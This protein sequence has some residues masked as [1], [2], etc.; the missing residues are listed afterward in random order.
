MEILKSRTAA[1][2]AAIVLFLAVGYIYCSPVLSGKTL[3]RF[4]NQMWRGA[5]HESEVYR[6]TTGDQ[7][8][9]TRSMFC[10]MPNYQ[11]GGAEYK[12]GKFIQPLLRF[13]DGFDRYGWT[14]FLYF[15]G[16]YVMFIAFGV[17]PWLSIVAA[18]ATGLSS[19]FIVLIPAGHTTKALTIATTAFVLGGFKFIYDKKY[20]PG[21]ILT[22]LFVSAGFNRHPQMFYYFCMMMGVLGLAELW[23]HVKEKRMKDFL[24]SSVIFV[25]SL[26]IGFGTRMSNVFANAE[27][28]SQTTRGGV[29]ELAQNT[30]E[31]PQKGLKHDSALTFSYGVDETLSLLIPGIKGGSTAMHTAKT[32]KLY[33]NLRNIGVDPQQSSMVAER[34]PL[35]WGDQPFT[36]GNVYVGA[37]VCFLFLLGLLVLE[38]PYKW[39]LLASTIFSILLAW[40]SNFYWFS[41]L[42]LDYFP[43]YNKFRAV[44][45][46]LVVAEV[47][48]P[49]LG[50]MTVK[51]II[52]GKLDREKLEN[53]ILLSA[54]ITAGL[55]LILA[56]FSGV[57]FD[58][59]GPRDSEIGTFSSQRIY[60]AFID[61]RHHLAVADCIRSAVII[62]AAAAALWFLTKTEKKKVALVAVLGAIM[63]IDLWGVDTRYFHK[64]AFMDPQKVEV[65]FEQT[66][67]EK[68]ILTDSTDFRVYNATTNTF[69]DART[70]YYL[71]SIGGYSSAK[72]RRYQDLIDRYL[73][74]ANLNVLAMLNTK[75][76]IT[77]GE[78][79][80]HGQIMTMKPYGNAWFVKALLVADSAKEE[81]DAVGFYDLSKAAVVGKDFSAFAKN[82]RPGVAYDAKIDL[83]KVSPKTLEYECNSSRAGTVVFSEIYYP[84]GWKSYIDGKPAEHFRADYILR[85]MNVPSGHHTITFT[86]DPDSIKKGDALAIFF[87]TLMYLISAGLIGW[88]I[89]R[90]LSLSRK[91]KSA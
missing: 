55:C 57:I 9:W 38:G 46:I 36:F 10:G 33:K 74:N 1:W 37:A 69:S 22:M 65:S 48:M 66:D 83:V 49:L 88:S 70:S 77:N 31:A 41:K 3:D 40:G 68:F 45:S 7:T 34:A 12:S 47:A 25:L 84:F 21:V 80:D 50:F 18:L 53:G 27:Y 56:V 91:G 58:F 89:W 71:K 73:K 81:L 52:S 6:N 76:L 19:Y 78:N 72:L 51:E 16:F 28:V 60:D 24:I 23:I 67:Y 29:N 86:F 63:L 14:M 13:V 39:A 17:G 44:S 35:Y 8:W 59:V 87:I 43:L 32:G 79:S 85:A 5:V 42:F 62:L 61:A 64:S 15:L 20:V 82:L 2:I 54:G 26:G 75:Y 90:R 4:D 30:S 11:I